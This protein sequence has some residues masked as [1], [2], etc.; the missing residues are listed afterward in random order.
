M[1][2]LVGINIYHPLHVC[3]VFAYFVSL[4]AFAFRLSYYVLDTCL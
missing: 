4:L 3:I 2:P 1:S